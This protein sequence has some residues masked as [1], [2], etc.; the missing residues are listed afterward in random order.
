[1]T[2]ARAS[3]M[4]ANASSS[5]ASNSICLPQT[6]VAID[7]S[8]FKAVNSWDNNFTSR[9]LE[10]RMKETEESIERYLAAL[11]T[12]DKTTGY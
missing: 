6:I 1:M 3:A 8:K 11:E 5:C 4:S 12:A 7:G 9:K 10:E 2:T